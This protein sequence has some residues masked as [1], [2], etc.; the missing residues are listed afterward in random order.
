[1]FVLPDATITAQHFCGLAPGHV[2]NVRDLGNSKDKA[3]VGG[4]NGQ[5]TKEIEAAAEGEEVTQVPCTY[6]PPV[7][8][9]PVQGIGTRGLTMVSTR[10]SSGSLASWP[11]SMALQPSSTAS[12]PSPMASWPTSIT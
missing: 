4:A 9:T 2:N 10:T 3:E 5:D 6:S 7:Q 12:P 11:S 8:L 1:V